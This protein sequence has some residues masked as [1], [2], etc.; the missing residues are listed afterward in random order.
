M[1]AGAIREVGVSSLMDTWLLLRNIEHNGERNRTLQVLKSRGMAH[2][3]Q[4]REF[5]LSKRGIELVDV[6]VSGRMF[7]P[8]PRGS[9]SRPRR[10]LQIVCE[11]SITIVCWTS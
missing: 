11:S 6:Y 1:L 10:L 7:S 2:S 9:R 8:A 3:N 5:I 4:V